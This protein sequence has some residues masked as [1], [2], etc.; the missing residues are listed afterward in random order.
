MNTIYKT[1][2][3]NF[4]KIY[5]IEENLIREIM[6]NHDKLFKKISLKNGIKERIKIFKVCKKLNK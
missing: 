4:K 1:I 3:K 6:I 5:F 2:P